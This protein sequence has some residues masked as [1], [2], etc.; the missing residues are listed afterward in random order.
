MERALRRD[1]LEE[2]TMQLNPEGHMERRAHTVREDEGGAL[3]RGSCGQ[4]CGDGNVSS[5]S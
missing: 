4:R 1:F 5:L 3:G 2:V